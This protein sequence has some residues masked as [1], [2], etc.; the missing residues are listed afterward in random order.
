MWKSV[1]KVDFYR[2]INKSVLYDDCEET[3]HC[4]ATQTNIKLGQAQI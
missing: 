3:L 4:T 1:K 2:E